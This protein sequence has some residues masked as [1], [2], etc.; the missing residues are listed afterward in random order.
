VSDELHCP[1][2]SSRL[3]LRNDKTQSIS[4]FQRKIDF[5]QNRFAAKG[6]VSGDFLSR[7]G[8]CNESKIGNSLDDLNGPNTMGESR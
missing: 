5:T 1:R 4:L 6:V 3:A 8:V 7:S 2:R